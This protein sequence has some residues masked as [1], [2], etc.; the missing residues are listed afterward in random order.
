M[1]Q[2]PRRVRF[3]RAELDAIIT[4]ACIAEAGSPEGD[5][6]EWTPE[7]Y[8]AADSAAAKAAELIHRLDAKT[9]EQKILA[10]LE[11][12]KFDGGRRKR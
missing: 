3:T 9:I 10:D 6:Q 12:G 11:A 5:Y 7:T 4:M 2:P 1:K 8:K